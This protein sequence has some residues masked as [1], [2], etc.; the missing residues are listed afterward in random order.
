MALKTVRNIAIILAL[1]ALV[2]LVPGGGT[3][4]SVALQA[5]SLAFLAVLVWF[6]ALMYRQRRTELYG[7]GDRRRAILYA[8]LAVGT[9]TLTATPRLWETAAGSVAWLILVAGAVYAV[10]AVVWSARRY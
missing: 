10:I 3:G 6:A 4:S 9:L 1:A 7:L 5:V 8:A 2:V